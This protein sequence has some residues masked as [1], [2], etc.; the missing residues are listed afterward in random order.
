MLNLLLSQIKALPFDFD[1]EVAKFLQA[2]KDHLMTEGKPAPTAHPMVEASVI[3]I[4]G[5]VLDAARGIVEPDD[6]KADYQIAD[7]TPAPPTLEQ[8][9]AAL[10]QLALN[11]AASLIEQI[12]PRLKSRLFDFQVR[13]ASARRLSGTASD[14]DEEVMDEHA[15]RGEKQDAIMRHLAEV[16]SQIHDLTADH[17]DVWKAPPFP[18]V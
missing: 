10:A 8:K 9:K 3:R 17:V 11:E 14:A 7:D 6:F 4:P 18:K 13:D 15:S 5:K 1:A 16:E 2:K 12:A